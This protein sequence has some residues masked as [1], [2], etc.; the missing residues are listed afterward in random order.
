MTS[1][2]KM[3]HPKNKKRVKPRDEELEKEV[4]SKSS[5]QNSSEHLELGKKSSSSS[6]LTRISA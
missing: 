3:G 5:S 4:S 2:K 6:M 1:K